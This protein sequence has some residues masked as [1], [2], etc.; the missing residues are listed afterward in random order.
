MVESRGL[1]KRGQ[2]WIERTMFPSLD[3]DQENRANLKRVFHE[4]MK[5]SGQRKMLELNQLRNKLPMK[6]KKLTAGVTDQE[7]AWRILE[8]AYTS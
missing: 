3:W 7:E 2:Y 1:Q 4:L 5:N 6:A 8:E